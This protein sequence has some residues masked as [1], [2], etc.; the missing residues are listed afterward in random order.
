MNSAA[1]A[2]RLLR[3]AVDFTRP[4]SAYG[5]ITVIFSL[6]RLLIH[7][8]PDQGDRTNM[9]TVTAGNK[10]MAAA[11]QFLN[12]CPDFLSENCFAYRKVLIF[13]TVFLPAAV[14]RC[15]VLKYNFIFPD[16]HSAPERHCY[17]A[18]AGYYCRSAQAEPPRS[19]SMA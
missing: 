3:P 18:Q 19:G 1:N 12:G 5:R 4:F 2:D 7:F 13:Q 11:V 17:S 8:L 10:D 14:Y 16:Y 6:Y 15:P 9:R